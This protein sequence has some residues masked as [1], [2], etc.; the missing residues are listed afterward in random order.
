MG[1]EHTAK[2][3]GI[4][5]T[6][7]QVITDFNRFL[8]SFIPEKWEKEKEFAFQSPRKAHESGIL[9]ISGDVDKNRTDNLQIGGKAAAVHTGCSLGHITDQLV[10]L[11]SPKPS[12]YLH[13]SPPLFCLPSYHFFRAKG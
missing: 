3:L 13:S 1:K 10:L 7:I 2:T 11:P 9:G 8:K 4:W 12:L 5:K 6:D